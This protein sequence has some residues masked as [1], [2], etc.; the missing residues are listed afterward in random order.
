[1]GIRVILST[2]VY[3]RTG[4]SIP[5]IDQ[6][7]IA[8]GR[9]AWQQYNFTSRSAWGAANAV[10]GN[11]TDRSAGGNQCTISENKKQTAEWRVDLG[12][13][14][15]I[16]HIDIFYRTDNFPSPGPYY[17]RFAGFFLYVSNSTSKENGHLC[18]HELQNATDTPTEN[19]TI[20][21][22]VHGRY[23]IYYN[24]RRPDVTYPSYY[25]EYAYNELCELEVY[26]CSNAGKYGENCDVPCPENCQEQGC[27]INNGECLGCIPG[28][29]GLSCNRSCDNH[30][31]GL[32]C[33]LSCGN[34]SDGETCHHVN[35]TCINGC[36]AGVEGE[37]CL[38]A[39]DHG[40]YGEDCVHNCSD[41][42]GVPNRC[43]RFTGECEEGCQPGWRG[44]K[45]DKE[46]DGGMY[47]YNCNETCGHCLNDAQCHHING[48]CLD[49]CSA[50]YEGSLCVRATPQTVKK[51][52]KNIYENI[53][54]TSESRN[55][56][57]S[58]YIPR[59]GTQEMKASNV[60]VDDDIDNDEKIH[61][62]N[63]YGDFYMN[64]ETIPDINIDQLENIIREKQQNEDDGFQ[65]E[66]AALPY[67]ERYPCNAGKQPENIPKNRFKTT[68]PYDHSRI[69][70][71]NSQSD[72]INANFI[73]GINETNKYIAA[74]GPRQ[75]TVIDFWTMIW[76]ENVNQL[77]MLTNL[78][79][80]N[81]TKCSKYWPDL[82]QT[83]TFGVVSI[84][85]EEEHEYACY[86]I[87]KFRVT[88]QGI[89]KSRVVTQYHYTAWPDHGVPELLCLVVFHDHVTR[90]AYQQNSGPTLVHCSAGIGRT[91]TYIAIDAL[92]KAGKIEGKVN[93]AEYVKKM[94]ENRMNMVQTY[95]QYMTIFLALDTMFKAP[96]CVQTKHEFLRK[97]ELI[98]RDKPANKSELRMEFQ[99]L[100]RVRP[101][102]TE[103]DYKIAV[104]N[105]DSNAVL[106]LDKYSMFL[107][108]RVPKRGN[109]INAVTLSSYTNPNAF[110][111]T[112]YP[113]QEDAVDFLR[114]LTDHE[115][116]IVICMDPLS[117]IESR[118]AWLPDINSS[119]TVS[120]YTVHSEH[121][122]LTDVKCTTIS[123][124]Q[125]MANVEECSVS[126][127][128]PKESSKTIEHAQA[129][130][131][132]L[133]LVSFALQSET[134]GPITIISSDGAVLCGV[135]CAVYNTL[136]QLSMDGELDIFSTVRQLQIRR[137]ELCSSMDEY[138]M[139]YDVLLN[140]IRTQGDTSEENVYYNQ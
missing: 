39:C 117:N 25:S 98:T 120:L 102:Y 23:V 64:E 31:Y 19:Q 92:Y 125:K 83:T 54:V 30:T 16:S 75:N 33:S 59:S 112:H 36:I 68:F 67:G 50:G 138:R 65:R 21:C 53:D 46:C 85:S 24:E 101:S 10:D 131:E 58:R 134:E 135:F 108:S 137:P 95:E 127:I 106:H 96:T 1:M 32:E 118:K 34:C 91:G 130:A 66:Y 79:E 6:E 69:K 28:Y 129:V 71:S 13:V 62:E 132:M 5:S 27:N 73:D 121:E 70:L 40:S 63:P 22:P 52:F 41:N 4:T 15:S 104:Q 88:H 119:K 128:E 7:N 47:G 42:C 136:Q 124:T 60:E 111:V 77:V 3:S 20:S 90:T 113:S 107:S 74:Q 97:A 109:Y 86:N 14:V 12:S 140:Y 56:S 78:K 11:Y 116:D 100:L 84:Q 72:Y 87:R 48:T 51:D 44:I 93:I 61:D 139:V 76:Q 122:Q 81:K 82:H 110:I 123:V 55:T 45:C 105:G 9:P 99:N 37:K 17:N 8:L 114:L 94:R 57:G 126:I 29:Q 35:G 49:G 133:C 2:C 18:F 103:V 26:G 43:D 115:S 80:G 38:K 89:K